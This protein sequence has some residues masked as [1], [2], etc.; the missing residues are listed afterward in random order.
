MITI[1]VR[2]TMATIVITKVLMHV[3][4]ITVLLRVGKV[5]GISWILGL[6]G[7]LRLLREPLA[8]FCC[9]RS[10]VVSTT[11]LAYTRSVEVVVYQRT[12]GG[13]ILLSLT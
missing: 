11:S 8:T 5:F 2:V 10:I 6:L 12:C 3:R 4:E 7:V 13:T 1:A 9:C